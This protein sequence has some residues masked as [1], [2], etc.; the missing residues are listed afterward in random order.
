MASRNSSTRPWRSSSNCPC[1]A[2][3]SATRGHAPQ[4]GQG[5][6]E[7]KSGGGWRL[8]CKYQEDPALPTAGE[9]TRY[10][11]FEPLVRRLATQ[12]GGRTPGTASQ[13]NQPAYHQTQNE[14]LVQKTGQTPELPTTHHE[15]PTFHQDADLNGIGSKAVHS[16]S[17][18]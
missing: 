8:V 5:T 16:P 17:A 6:P 10:L 12:G 3:L 14:Q 18:Q 1:S 11:R 15:L 4:T 9:S 7:V 13:S 2:P